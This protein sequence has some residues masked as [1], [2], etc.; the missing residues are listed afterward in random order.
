MRVVGLPTGE[1]PSLGDSAG[2]TRYRSQLLVA[3]WQDC[4]IV[5]HLSM[6]DDRAMIMCSRQGDMYMLPLLPQNRQ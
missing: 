4:P 6:G 1:S 2:F 3:N 5:Y